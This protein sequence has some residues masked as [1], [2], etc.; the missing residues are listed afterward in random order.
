MSEQRR[1]ELYAKSTRSTQFT[2][3][4]DRDKW[5]TK[6]LKSLNKSIK[7]KDDQIKRL[8]QVGNAFEWRHEVMRLK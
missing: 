2:R 5:I 1:K 4:E 6:E 7:D 3:K 8:S